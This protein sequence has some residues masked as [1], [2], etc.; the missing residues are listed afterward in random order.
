MML[1]L[2]SLYHCTLLFSGR[3]CILMY[4][5]LFYS[6]VF[7]FFWILIFYCYNKGI[8]ITILYRAWYI[9]RNPGHCL[10]KVLVTDKLSDC[11]SY[12]YVW[13]IYRS[14]MSSIC[15]SKNALSGNKEQLKFAHSLSKSGV[16]AVFGTRP[17]SFQ[18]A[19][20]SQIPF[21]GGNCRFLPFVAFVFLTDKT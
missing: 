20:I 3:L 6:I 17:F 8:G 5:I 10:F 4:S 11:A 16:E 15:V 7:P 18:V 19:N 12:L 2:G 13:S 1:D 9:F 21:S 14:V